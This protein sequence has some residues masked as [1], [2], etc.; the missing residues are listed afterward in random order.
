MPFMKFL[1][2]NAGQPDIVRARSDR[3]KTL[4]EQSQRILRNDSDLTSGEREFIGAYTSGLNQ[5]AH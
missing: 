3:L 1:P 5:C 2:E 4:P